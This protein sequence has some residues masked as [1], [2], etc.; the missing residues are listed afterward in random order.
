MHRERARKKQWNEDGPE[1]YRNGRDAPR[2]AL[3]LRI[4]SA[5]H[6]LSAIDQNLRGAEGNARYDDDETLSGLFSST[7]GEW[8]ETLVR[9]TELDDAGVRALLP[10]WLVAEHDAAHNAGRPRS[11]HDAQA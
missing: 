6:C 3:S 11:E 9:L 8:A 5:R 4:A 7:V 10:S 1:R 2:K